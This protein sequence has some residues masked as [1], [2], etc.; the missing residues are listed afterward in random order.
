MADTRASCLSGWEPLHQVSSN[1]P[2]SLSSSLSTS[3]GLVFIRNILD[4]FLLARL[5]QGRGVTFLNI[6]N[7]NLSDEQKP[8]TET[9]ENKE[10]MN[11]SVLSDTEVGHGKGVSILDIKCLYS[12]SQAPARTPM[13][14]YS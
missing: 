8:V 4:V 5:G 14:R 11:S 3:Q 7:D 9:P 2:T 1:S 12:A 13:C 6:S 10:N